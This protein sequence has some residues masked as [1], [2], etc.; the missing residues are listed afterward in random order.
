MSIILE[1]AEDLRK[2]A[3]ELLLTERNAIDEK[4]TT[5]GYD[6]A[7]T[8]KK[9]RA[10]SKCGSADHNSRTCTVIPESTTA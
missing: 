3:V 10:C 7:G 5:L 8:A 6:G 1:Q 9:V 4:L 2:R